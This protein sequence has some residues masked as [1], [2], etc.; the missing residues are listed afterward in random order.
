MNH[1]FIRKIDIAYSE[2]SISSKNIVSHLLNLN[3][4][5]EPDPHFDTVLTGYM[6]RGLI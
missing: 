5:F 6:W 2:K 3:L 4:M 1:F